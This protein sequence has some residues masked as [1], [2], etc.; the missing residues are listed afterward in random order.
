[1][2]YEFQSWGRLPGTKQTGV[3]LW[4]RSDPLPVPDGSSILP[5]GQGRSYG[6]C[7]LNADGLVLATDRLDRFID[8]DPVRGTLTCEAGMRLAEIVDVFLPKGWFLPVVPGTQFVSVGGAIANDVHG[9][10]H[11]RVGTFGCHVVKFELLRSN[12]ERLVCSEQENAGWFRA[13]IG[14]LGLTGLITWAQLKLRRINS[15]LVEVR[16]PATD[17]ML[18]CRCPSTCPHGCSTRPP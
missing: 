6:D 12:G 2:K 15:A 14:G 7:C 13:T 18:P 16:C 9:K 1:M 17:P 3:R 4:A 5:Y 8:F 11:H 10:N